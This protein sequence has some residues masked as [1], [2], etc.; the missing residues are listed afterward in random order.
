MTTIVETGAT[1]VI[2]ASPRRG[3][4]LAAAIGLLIL[5]LVGVGIAGVIYAHTYQPLGAAGF[6][7]PA[8]RSVRLIGDGETTTR[9]ALAGRAGT[10]GVVDYGV[11]N[12][13]RFSI[14][15]LGT[16][17]VPPDGMTGLKWSDLSAD[18]PGGGAELGLV[19]HAR[20]FP[21]TLHPG[22]SVFIQ[23]SVVKEGCGSSAD[24][25][26]GSFPI[27]WEALGVHHEWTFNL[28]NQQGGSSGNLPILFCPSKAA[29]AH[30]DNR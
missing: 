10:T 25:E 8:T 11:R 23:V 7:G 9:Y 5:A 14:R 20:N 12:D 13:G 21:V 1:P 16:D 17:A 4:W 3:R 28:G 22:E 15:L 24:I 26:V 19:S 27:R 29:L 18:D 30:T 6:Y 2:A